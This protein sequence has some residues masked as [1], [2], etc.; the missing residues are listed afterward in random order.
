MNIEF[1]IINKKIRQKTNFKQK[2]DINCL[3]KFITSDWDS[4]EKYVIFW[5]NKG[6]SII[7]SIGKNN[8]SL[9]KVPD[10]ILNE[11]YFSIQIYSDD[12]IST[13]KIK[14]DSFIEAEDC[15]HKIDII[16]EQS[17]EKNCNKCHEGIDENYIIDNVKYKHNKIFFYSDNK[18]IETIDIFDS[19]LL[20]KIKSNLSLEVVVDDVL[21]ENSNNPIANKAVYNALL[22]FLKI[23]DLSTIALTGDYNDLKNIP[24]EF[25]PTHHNHV[26]VD[27][28]DYEE[29]IN[30]DLNA[31]LDAL[32]DEI[33]KE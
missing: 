29:N 18:L 9:C 28:V 27:V 3:F 30:I 16:E 25:N 14:V 24:T 2:N 32:G 5:N 19:E 31:L 8:E 11:E 20:N 1:E 22:E 13:N 10:L 12:N 21:S 7:Q 33:A 15:F 17:K 26:V 23:S 4:L 6:K